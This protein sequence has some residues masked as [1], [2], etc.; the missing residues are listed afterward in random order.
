MKNQSIYFTVDTVIT[1]QVILE[2]FDRSGIDI[3]EIVSVQRK[4]SNNSWVVTFDSPVT[5]EAALEVASIEINGVTVFLGDCEHRLVLVK[6]Y[7]APEEL[8]DTALIGR[9]LHYGR[10]L[11]F[12]RDL[13]A[14]G[15][16]KGVR[17][18]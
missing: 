17:M 16:H 7:E 13:I 14:E 1:S 10:V 12:R 9:L 3:E 6:M 4:A 15:I 5:K 11:S 2:A 18:A 8:P